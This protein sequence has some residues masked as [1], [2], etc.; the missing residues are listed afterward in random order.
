[1]SADPTCL[2]FVYPE[3]PRKDSKTEERRLRLQEI[4]DGQA[5][6]LL[7]S[8]LGLRCRGVFINNPYPREKSQAEQEM[9]FR[10]ECSGVTTILLTTRPPLDDPSN[11][12]MKAETNHGSAANEQG[13]RRRIRRSGNWAETMILERLRQVF[14]YCDRK[15][16]RL[17][18]SLAVDDDLDRPFYFQHSDE[19]FVVSHRP[20]SK[21]GGSAKD[22]T[23]AYFVRIREVWPGSPNLVCAFGLSGPMTLA[24]SYLVATN[25]ACAERIL[26]PGGRFLMARLTLDRMIP[27]E[28]HFL[29]FVDRWDIRFLI[30]QPLS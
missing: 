7:A 9:E 13:G 27:N 20:S 26:S 25:P 24:W 22:W 16:I 29:S 3:H 6:H 5:G 1:M 30:D 10:K 8:A 14:T 21:G 2:L 19:A 17:G 12:P 23:L 11:E 18:K 15:E 4:R 28:P